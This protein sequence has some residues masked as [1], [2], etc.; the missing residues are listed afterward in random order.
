[1][2]NAKAQHRKGQFERFLWRYSDDNQAGEF[3]G[4]YRSLSDHSEMLSLFR[5]YR[6]PLGCLFFLGSRL[7][8]ASS[9]RSKTA[10]NWRRT[11]YRHN[12]KPVT[13]KSLRAVRAV[14]PSFW[15]RKELHD[16]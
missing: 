14:K 16:W 10:L 11:G 8:P 3:D 13:Q 12:R 5:Q 9:H 15:P 6:Q 2:L 7:D 4:F 1:M